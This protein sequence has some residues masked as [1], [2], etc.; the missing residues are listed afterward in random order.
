MEHRY[1][2]NDISLK[3]MIIKLYASS[4]IVHDKRNKVNMNLLC[5]SLKSEHIYMVYELLINTSVF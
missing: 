3:A 5:L 2:T 1:D 4:A